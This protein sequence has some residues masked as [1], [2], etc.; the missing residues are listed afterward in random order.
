M[1][2]LIDNNRVEFLGIEVIFTG[3]DDPQGIHRGS[4][5]H[6]SIISFFLQPFALV[7]ISPFLGRD[8]SLCR[9]CS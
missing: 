4:S 1:A 2:I 7:D 9:G 8:L 6:A 5:A 3:E